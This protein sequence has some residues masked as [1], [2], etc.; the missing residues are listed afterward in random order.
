MVVC[1]LILSSLWLILKAM[2]NTNVT[3]ELALQ[4]LLLSFQQSHVHY[5]WYDNFMYQPEVI[6]AKKLTKQLS[7]QGN[8]QV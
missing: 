7:Y 5:G 1:E 8:Q 2:E 3:M 4:G 6:E